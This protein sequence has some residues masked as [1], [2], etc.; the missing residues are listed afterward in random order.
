MPGLIRRA[1]TRL[2][3]EGFQQTLIRTGNRLVESWYDWRLGISSASYIR[4]AELGIDDPDY[5]DYEPTDY[6]DLWRILD[7]LSIRPGCDVLLDYGAG[8]GRMMAAAALYPFRKIIGIELTERLSA[9]AREN[10]RRLR[11]PVRCRDIELITADACDYAVPS[12]VTAVYIFHSFSGAV[13]AK[14]LERVRQSIEESPRKITLSFCTPP[15]FQQDPLGGCDWLTR[16]RQI[17]GSR[18]RT[19]HFY[20]TPD[21]R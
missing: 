18:G 21:A 1:W 11:G 14:V 13:L 2:K 8:M 10:I 12:E 20:Q 9:V 5:H 4:M 17:K 19:I 6:R 16:C 7:G 15:E 3:N